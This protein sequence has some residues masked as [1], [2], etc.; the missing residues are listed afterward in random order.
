MSLVTCDPPAPPVYRG[1][2]PSAPSRS[3]AIDLLRI[4]GVGAVAIGHMWA[5]PADDQ[6][7]VRT[8]I[9]SWHVP[10]FFFLT[11]YLWTPG[12]S[13]AREVRSRGRS[14]LLP[15][16]AWIAV[17]GIPVAVWTTVQDGFP[18]EA[19]AKNVWGG[20]IVR[21]PFAPY[22]F[23]PVLFFVAVLHRWLERCA[24][25]V[26]VAVGA[27]GLAA[28]YPWGD[29][30]MRAPLDV[31]FAV[32]CLLL[33]VAGQALRRH[34]D[35][36][37]APLLTGLALLV[38]SAVALQTGL[39]EP[40][41]MKLGEFGTPVLSMAVAVAICSGL[42]LVLQAL[43]PAKGFRFGGAISELAMISVVVLLT[44]TMFYYLLRHQ[45]LGRVETVALTAP[46]TIGLGLLVHRTPLSQVF[47]GVPQRQK[48]LDPVASR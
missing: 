32:P 17:I 27:V 29:Q 42:L 15:Y 26:P 6:T 39:A 8:F 24:A 3:V 45:G 7:A 14:L 46:L 43:E 44:H 35:R 34:R 4:I 13:L 48:E 9:Y 31:L 11:G 22:W 30:L 40:L 1:A 41:D 12:R 20:G 38:V 2:V 5:G 36:V 28:C 37:P 18:L 21:G 10:V 33:V 19:I 16:A 47:A 23:L 25:W